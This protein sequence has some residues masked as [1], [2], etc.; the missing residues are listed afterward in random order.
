MNFLNSLNSKNEFCFRNLKVVC[1]GMYD[2]LSLK[3]TEKCKELTCKAPLPFE[4]KDY[5]T[6]KKTNCKFLSWHLKL[7]ELSKINNPKSSLKNCSIFK[8]ESSNFC[9]NG[10]NCMLKISFKGAKINATSKMACM[11]PND[12]SFICGKHCA[13][14]SIICNTIKNPTNKINNSCG[15]SN[16]TYYFKKS[17]F[18]FLLRF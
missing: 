10:E 2:K 4:C 8:D 6:N 1:T 13:R 17:P 9:Q 16:D 18:S 12:K 7:L 3:Y 11:C 15:N 5:C 14:D